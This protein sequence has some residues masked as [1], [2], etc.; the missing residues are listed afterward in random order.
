M[1]QPFENIIAEKVYD[2]STA[3]KQVQAWQFEENKVVFTNG[4]FDLIHIG[5]LS[6]LAK[7]AALG[8]KLIIGLNSD[9]SV[10]Q[11]KGPARP[12]NDQSSRAALLAC[13]CFVDMVIIFGDNTPLNLII[14]LKPDILVKGADYSVENIVGAAEV[15]ANGGE[16][17]TIHFVDGYSSTAIMEKVKNQ[18]S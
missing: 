6:Y 10:R 16:V 5:H 12:V 7:S 11:I 15:I 4:V 3:K 9:S 2:L 13:L 8:N 17:K 18:G 1:T 14:D